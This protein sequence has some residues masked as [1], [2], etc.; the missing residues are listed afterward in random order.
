MTLKQFLQHHRATKTSTTS[1]VV[2]KITK[3]QTSDSGQYKALVFNNVGGVEV[4][5]NIVVKGSVKVFY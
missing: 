3:C 2:L 1:E 5:A 4:T